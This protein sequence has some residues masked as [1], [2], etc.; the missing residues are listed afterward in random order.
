MID[1][2]VRKGEEINRHIEESESNM[3][4]G[5]EIAC[6][7]HKPGNTRI[8]PVEDSCRIH[9]PLELPEKIKPAGNFILECHIQKYEKLN[10]CCFK[11]ASF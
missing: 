9:S 6:C 1:V 3:T 11:L 4:T 2:P 5:A 7:I 8:A 10:I